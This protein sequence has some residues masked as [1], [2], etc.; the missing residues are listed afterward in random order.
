MAEKSMSDIYWF[1]KWDRVLEKSSSDFKWF[2]GGRT[3]IGYN[4]VDYKIPQYKD[5]T[6]Y[7]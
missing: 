1:K 2:I 4:C 7:I 6:A 3:N 5:K